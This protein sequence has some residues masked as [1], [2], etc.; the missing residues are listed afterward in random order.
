MSGEVIIQTGVSG[1]VEVASGI[2]LTAD[3][4][5]QADA[6]NT[7]A[8]LMVA[9]EEDYPEFEALLEVTSGTP[10]ENNTVEINIRAK[11]DG[12]NEEP[13]PS[14]DFAPHF[15][16]KFTLDNTAS[17]SYYAFG[18]SNIDKLGTFYLKSNEA[19]TTL[20]VTLSIRMKSLN[21]AA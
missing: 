6:T 19:S 20:T 9:T 17:S 2:S 3:I 15:L 8:A 11:A 1:Y 21:A 14:G 12:T 4:W 18:L 10:T 7:I 13:A 5:V 16:G